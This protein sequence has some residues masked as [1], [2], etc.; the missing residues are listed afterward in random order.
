MSVCPQTGITLPECSC[1]Q[2]LTAQVRQFQPALLQADPIGEIRVSRLQ[3]P[4]DSGTRNPRAS[5]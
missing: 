5:A 4:A 3:S 1:I 2:C